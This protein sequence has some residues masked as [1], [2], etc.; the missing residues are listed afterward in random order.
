VSNTT[1]SRF[2]SPRQ[3]APGVRQRAD[4]PERV[5]QLVADHADYLLPGRHFLPRQLAREPLDLEQPVRA[6]L[7]V[8][9]ALRQVEGFLLVV[10][11]RAEQAVAVLGDRARERLGRAGDDRVETLAL[12]RPAAVEQL[13]RGEVRIHD[14]AARLDQHQRGRRVLHHGVEQQLALEQ[15]LA[16]LAQ[17]AAKLVVRGNQLAKL[18]APAR[19]DREA[20]VA[21][22]ERDHAARQRANQRPD[23]P[24]QQPREHERRDR[25]C[26]HGHR[27]AELRRTERGRRPRRQ[28]RR[29]GQHD[30]ERGGKLSFQRDEAHGGRDQGLGIGDSEKAGALMARQ[31]YPV[32]RTG[33]PS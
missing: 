29:S 20:E 11:R 23:R 31:L 14:V 19:A 27:R 12:E 26:Q 6:A 10:D 1:F 21:V 9:R 28:R 15:V 24:R 8:E 13:P 3:L 17:H 7:Q 4:R 18:V 5:V 32:H 25:Q 16:L 30:R 2:T 33:A 22:A